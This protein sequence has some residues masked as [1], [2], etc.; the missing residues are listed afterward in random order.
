MIAEDVIDELK[1]QAMAATYNLDSP[2]RR[3]VCPKDEQKQKLGRSPDGWDAVNLSYCEGPEQESGGLPFVLYT[4]RDPL[5]R[6]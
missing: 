4:R 1:A 6:G 3:V 2:G 5:G